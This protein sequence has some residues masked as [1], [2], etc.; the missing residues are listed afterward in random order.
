MSPNVSGKTTLLSMIYGNNTKGYG[1]DVYL[2][3]KK[4]GSG[5]SV[6][7]IKQNIGYISP[8]M[9]ELFK[10]HQMVL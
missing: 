3:G 2:F 7:D 5:E 8:S 9:L 6:W 1:Q 10:R 4:K